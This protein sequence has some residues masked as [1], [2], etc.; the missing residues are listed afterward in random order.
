[1]LMI[2]FVVIVAIAAVFMMD[3]ILHYRPP[4]SSEEIQESY[5][6][7][8]HEVIC[9][10]MA[11]QKFYKKLSSSCS[12]VQVFPVDKDETPYGDYNKPADRI[13]I[14]LLL[15][16]R[17]DELYLPYFNNCAEET[18]CD[19]F[20]RLDDSEGLTY[21]KGIT[22]RFKGKYKK[23]MPVLHKALIEQF[24]DLNIKFDGSRIMIDHL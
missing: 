5:S 17:I 11:L 22:Y 15:R 18:G 10:L 19:S 9:A 6:Q 3:Y 7:V 1:M 2:I 12:R 24:P 14:T 13:K 16:D 20:F 23:F 4:A 8:V 21:Y